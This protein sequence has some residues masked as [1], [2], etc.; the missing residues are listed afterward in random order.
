MAAVAD[1]A[2]GAGRAAM[3]GVHGD[4]LVLV[5]AGSEPPGPEIED[6]FGDGP[7]VRGR[8]GTGLREA[9]VSAAD[10]LAGLDVAAAWP[11]APRTIDA[12]DLLTERVLA[13]TSAPRRACGQRS[14]RRS[15][16]RRRRC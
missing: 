8:P 4:R 12:D 7:V 11:G 5:L 1:W 10:A 2:N 6:L 3:S 9:V 13:V 15:P 16:P 14:T